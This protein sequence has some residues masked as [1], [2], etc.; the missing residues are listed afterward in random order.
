MTPFTKAW[1]N[2][3]YSA[4][5]RDSVTCGIRYQSCPS[6][7]RGKKA[8]RIVLMADRS[9]SVDTLA[10]CIVLPLS[11]YSHQYLQT[12]VQNQFIEELKIVYSF[13]L[14]IHWDWIHF[15]FLSTSM[16]K[17]VSLYTHPWSI[18]GVLLNN[19]RNNP[20]LYLHSIISEPVWHLFLPWNQ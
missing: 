7:C 4:E 6:Y 18:I 9:S 10:I 1:W 12:N 13:T 20:C 5:P 17:A 19:Q 15:F 2:L 3:S 14:G 16:T 8:I 11:N